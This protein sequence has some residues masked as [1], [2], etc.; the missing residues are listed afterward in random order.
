MVEMLGGVMPA[1]DMPGGAGG[2]MGVRGVRRAVVRAAL[3]AGRVMGG[4]LVKGGL[5]LAA[6]WAGA[7]LVE[8][9]RDGEGVDG[10]GGLE[11]RV[12]DGNREWEKRGA[13]REKRRMKAWLQVLAA[14]YF[15]WVLLT[16]EYVFAR[17]MNTAA[18]L[19]AC[20][21]LLV[22]GRVGRIALVRTLESNW[23]QLPFVVWQLVHYLGHG[24]GPLLWRSVWCA[25]RGRPAL[26]L[27]VVGVVGGVRMLLK[28]RST[29]Y[30]ALEV[31]G[32]FVFLGYLLIAF[33]VL[34]LG[35]LGQPELTGTTPAKAQKSNA[36]GFLYQGGLKLKT[37]AIKASF[38]RTR[39]PQSTKRPGKQGVSGKRV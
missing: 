13:E 31:S 38:N 2:V 27:A 30:I 4:L 34:G 29:F 6:A 37:A 9:Y 36:G 14:G 24:V 22:G 23:A 17:G 10:M 11:G 21:R 20:Y 3:A 7:V 1:M 25:V 32:V 35:L 33:V 39:M 8:G 5:D 12:V 19:V 26:L 18:W 16:V 28:Y 15:L